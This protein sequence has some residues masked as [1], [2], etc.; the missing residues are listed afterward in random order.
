MGWLIT[1]G[2]A[3]LAGWQ[4]I[5][6]GPV[7][8]EVA[9]TFLFARDERRVKGLRAPVARDPSD[10]GAAALRAEALRIAT[11]PRVPSPGGWAA[12]A[13]VR[14]AWDWTP[15]G[16]GVTLRL[17]RVPRWAGLWY[18]TPLLDRYAHAWLWYHGGWDVIP[19]ESCPP[20][21]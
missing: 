6:L 21:S 15:A 17:D 13:G 20:A 9:V 5:P 12:P 16:S 7:L 1:G 3:I 8:F 14:P 10:P 4:Y 18:R 11:L 19:P 2:L